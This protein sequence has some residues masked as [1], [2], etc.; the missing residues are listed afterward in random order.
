[1]KEYSVSEVNLHIKNLIAGDFVLSNISIKGEIS[2]C[3]HHDRGHIYFTLKDDKSAIKAVLWNTRPRP[4]FLLEDGLKVIVTGSISVYDVGGYYQINALEI[5]R[6]G[7]GDLHLRLAK[8]K[9]E[10]AAM[11]YFSVQYKK[12]IPEFARKIGIVTARTGAAIQDI[13]HISKDRNPY[14][15]LFLYPALVQGEGAAP[16]IVKG[17]KTLDALGL[18]VIIIGRGGGSIEDLWAFNEQMTAEAVFMAKT[19]IVSA[20]GHETD[21]TLTDLIADVRAATPSDAARIAVCEWS[22]IQ[23]RIGAYRDGIYN[24][25]ERKLEDLQNKTENYRLKLKAAS[26]ESRLELQKKRAVNVKEMLNRILKNKLSI[27][28]SE[29]SMNSGKLSMLLKQKLTNYSSGVSKNS[30]KLS[31]LMEQKLSIQKQK[32]SGYAGKLSVLSPLNSL[33]RGYGYVEDDKGKRV[34]SVNDV[35]LE[36]KIKIYFTDGSVRAMIKEKTDGK[37]GYFGK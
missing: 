37:E 16:D 25:L 21:D 22:Y 27:Y 3:K 31:M 5:K 2:N 19:P 7:L 29:L 4:D 34:N 30:D 20:V 1:M 32:V 13:I 26:P 12:P 15:E 35:E 11:G 9:E 10:F 14:V 24:I 6:D 28:A 18:D 36:D 23:D 17:I 8:L 33:S